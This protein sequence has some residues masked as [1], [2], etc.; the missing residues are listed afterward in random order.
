MTHAN[1]KAEPTLRSYTHCFINSGEAGLSDFETPGQHEVILQALN[2]YLIYGSEEKQEKIFYGVENFEGT[3]PAWDVTSI[4][5]QEDGQHPDLAEFELQPEQALKKINGRR[6]GRLAGSKVL[7]G[8]GQPRLT[9]KINFSDPEVERLYNAGE[10]A[11]STALYARTKD[12]RLDGKVRPNHIL[13]FRPGKTQPRDLGSMF[14]NSIF[15]E[16]NDPKEG[17]SID[18]LDKILSDFT[19]SIKGMVGGGNGGGDG[20]GGGEGDGG[21]GGPGGDG[22]EGGGRLALANAALESKDIEIKNLKSK[23][24]EKDK[25]LKNTQDDLEKFKQAEADRVWT[26]LKN[27]TIPPGLIEN[28]E[29]EA[30]LRQLYN[31]DR[32]GFYQKILAVA[33]KAPN[34][35]KEGKEFTNSEQF[36]KLQSVNSAWD[37][38]TGATVAVKE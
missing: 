25:E 3:E 13:L 21:K 17:F 1:Q 32:D 37:Q 29:K 18:K 22:G 26:G 38:A 6:A 35:G 20:N 11:L 10:L 9:G 23:L 36:E 2:R 12:G 31:T 27:S 34:K 16:S 19:N 14:L 15:L 28:K 7:R 8:P 33:G 30:A 4:I 24:E 5:F